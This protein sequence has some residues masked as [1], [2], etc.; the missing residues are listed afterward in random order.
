MACGGWC[1]QG[2]RAEDGAHD[3]G[4]DGGRGA[5]GG[6]V[7]QHVCGRLVERRPRRLRRRHPETSRRACFAT[8]RLSRVMRR[9]DRRLACYRNRSGQLRLPLLCQ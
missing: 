2:R 4:E 7:G 8:A 3:E 9:V 6:E 5:V 1:P